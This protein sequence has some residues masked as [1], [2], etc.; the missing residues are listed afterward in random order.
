MLS[1]ISM[2]IRFGF[3]AIVQIV[4]MLFQ[5]CFSWLIALS[6]TTEGHLRF[7]PSI[8][9]PTDSLATGDQMYW[10]NEMSYTKNWRWQWFKRYWL[11]LNWGMRNPAYGFAD[12]AGFSAI[13]PVEFTTTAD[14]GDKDIDVGFAG[15]VAGSVYRTVETEGKKYFEYR[16]I[17]RRN[18]NIVW[19]LQ[20]GWSIP[21]KGPSDG[22][23][24]HLCVYVRLSVEG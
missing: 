1:N 4:L 15:T 9:E 17:K 22:D 3:L 21:A 13:N 2:F 20:M 6:V 18:S 5:F 23:Y 7:F 10:D 24:C 19:Y 14:L 8:F 16:K 12:Y 11:A